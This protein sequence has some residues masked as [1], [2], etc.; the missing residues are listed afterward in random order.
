M[1]RYGMT[2]KSAT[3]FVKSI[4]PQIRPNRYFRQQ[5]QQYEYD[6]YGSYSSIYRGTQS[7]N[8]SS[9]KNIKKKNKSMPSMPNPNR[10]TV[11]FQK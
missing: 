10:K 1:S 7:N 5:L 2:Y 3:D 11:K 6:L 9:K 4:R 8:I